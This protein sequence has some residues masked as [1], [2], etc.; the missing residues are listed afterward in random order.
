[1][2]DNESGQLGEYG[3]P[4]TGD[5]RGLYVLSLVLGAAPYPV[6]NEMGEECPFPFDPPQLV[7]QPLGQYHCPYCGAMVIAGMTH[8]NYAG[9]D[10][11]YERYM[12]E[13]EATT[14][15]GNVTTSNDS[16]DS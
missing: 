10:E 1:M 8:P 2:V 9:M 16:K 4:R 6:L 12:A 14:S 5:D 11:D 3:P 13:Q 15:G 7:G